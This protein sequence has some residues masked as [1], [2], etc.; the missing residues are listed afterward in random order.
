LLPFRFAGT[1]VLVALIPRAMADSTPSAGTD[2]KAALASRC[3]AIEEAYEFMLAYAAQGLPTDQGS[4]S[5][6]QIREF[7]GKCDAA[8]TGLSEAIARCTEELHLEPAAA[9]R[10]FAD[11]VESDAR[12][13]QSAVQLVLAQP[14]VGSAL[15]DNLNASTHLRAVLTDLFLIGDILKI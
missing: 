11:V 5:G 14:S 8:L 3:N 10:A 7:L 2:G 13:A 6:S 1:G 9:Y 4:L 15:I 12:A